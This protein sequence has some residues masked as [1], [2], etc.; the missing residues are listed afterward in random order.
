MKG[1]FCR[2]C[3]S[4]KFRQEKRNILL[5]SQN[6]EIKDIS[7]WICENCQEEFIDDSSITKLYANSIQSSKK[8]YLEA[9]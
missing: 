1:D 4:D 6:K 3:G 8:I 5:E 7:V 2:M 9:A